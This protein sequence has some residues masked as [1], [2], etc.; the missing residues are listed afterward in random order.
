MNPPDQKP[1]KKRKLVD[2]NLPNS[3]LSDTTFAVDSQMY[4]DLLEMEKKLDWTMMRKKAE[5]QDALNRP[6]PTTRTLRLF[7][8]HTVSGQ[9]WQTGEASTS[10][11]PNF[12]TGQGIPAWQLKLEGRLLE[13]PNQRSRDRVP[14]RQFSTFIKNMVIELDRDP[15]LYPDGNVVEWHRNPAHP[16]LDGFTVKRTGDTPTK[17]RLVL[18]LEHHPEQ[19]K[20]H[21]DLGGVLGLREE[22]RT[23]VIQALW[24]YIKIQGLQDK[25]DRKRIHA[26][27]VLRPIFGAEVIPFALL[28]ELVNRYL[29]PPDPIIIHYTVNPSIPPPE[30]PSAWD[31]EI[32]TEDLNL[33]AKMSSVSVGPNRESG[34]ELAKLD[35]EIAMLTQS[36]QSSVLKRQFLHSFADEPA[37]FIQSY[38]QSQS[39]DLESILGSGPTEGATIRREDLQRSEFFRMP[40]VEEAVAVWDG[41]RIASR[42][43]SASAGEVISSKD[44]SAVTDETREIEH[45][46]DLRREGVRRLHIAAGQYHRNI[47]K[48]KL[49]EALDDPDKFLPRDA[50]GIV[51]ITHG[52]EFGEESLFGTSLVKLG[53]AHCKVATLQEAF[54][55]TLQDTYLLSLTRIGDQIKEYEAER[56]KLETRRLNYD[57]AL[58]T[59]EK[60]NS[61]KKAKDKD[62][63]EA[64]EELT[65]AETRYEETSEDVRARI[66]A[67]QESEIDQMREL[68]AF[69]DNELNF[70]EQYVSVL[71]DVRA[72]WVDSGEISKMEY[73]RPSGPMHNFSRPEVD[74]KP[75]K[76]EKYSSVRSH[77]SR[78]SVNSLPKRAPSATPDA[79]SGSGSESSEGDSEPEPQGSRSR[80]SSIRSRTGSVRTASRP[81]SRPASRTGRKRSDSTT[82]TGSAV[83]KT[84]DSKKI[85]VTGWASSWRGKKDKDNFASLKDDDDDDEDEQLPRNTS[86]L[87][88]LS[89]KAKLKPKAKSSHSSPIVPSRGLKPPS[90]QKLVRALHDF[91]GSADELTFRVG[92][93]IVVMNEVLDGWWM[94]ELDG[95]KGLFPTSYTEVIPPSSTS[96]LNSLRPRVP[97]RAKSFA[98]ST[99]DSLSSES[100]HRHTLAIDPHDAGDHDEHPFSDHNHPFR[101]PSSG[102]FSYDTESLAESAAGDSEDEIGQRLVRPRNSNELLTDDD[103]RPAPRV[104]PPPPV[105]PRRPTETGRKAPPPPPPR[106]ATVSAN[107]TPQIIAASLSEQALLRVKA[108]P[109]VSSVSLPDSET[110]P[111]QNFQ[112]NPFK[113]NGMCS[114]CF[115]MHMTM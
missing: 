27:A 42:I 61:N 70:V 30:R 15:A 75:A 16:I 52:E 31:V 59:M 19:Y 44:K 29:L 60:I 103:A 71:R 73:R 9:T 39:R 114:N 25:V 45:E 3:I 84:Q 23:G 20:V 50:L 105:L 56:K 92:D 77:K 76:Q 108:S 33:K 58:K 4:Q 54:G 79:A 35:D 80:K 47:S 37:T 101:E 66:F 34:R 97:S 57:A 63:R 91:A 24:N 1:P 113:A 22:S 98:G 40:W 43:G 74:A 5:V 110:G 21:P 87:S 85:G 112:Q 89:N 17:I 109:F 18:H 46:I 88:F 111:C 11:T 90:Q 49:S 62:K 36:L 6:A 86:S 51:M 10:E 102:T 28:P 96:S 8:S 13:V 78:G 99:T 32:K 55:I 68:G 53:R 38:L 67:I 95:K 26:D 65:K 100:T 106:R 83:E 12:E 64:E 104:V 2:R 7:L 107:S 82:T 48:K 93:E 14:P 94:G 115:R 69:L 81:P 72:D 41:M